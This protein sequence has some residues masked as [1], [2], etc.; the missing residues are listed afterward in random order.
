MKCGNC[1]RLLVL[2]DDF[3]PNCGCKILKTTNQ[4]TNNQVIKK[5][6]KKSNGGKILIIILS[7]IILFLLI[8]ALLLSVGTNSRVQTNN[9]HVSGN[10]GSEYNITDG[11]VENNNITDNST[12]LRKRVIMI[13]MVGSNLESTAGA[14]STDINEMLSANVDKN[15]KIYV[16]TGGANSWVNP[17]I[18]AATNNIYEI[19]NKKLKLV[20]SLESTS[21]GMEKT[22]TT[23][24]NYVTDIT[25]SNNYSLILWDH[26]GGPIGGYGYDEVHNDMMYLDELYSSLKNTKFNSNNKLEF[27]GFDACL[28]ANIEIA[29]YL[30]NF[31]KYLIASEEIEPGSGWDYETFSNISR[32]STENLGKKIIDRYAEQAKYAFNIDGFTLSLIKLDRIPKV[33]DKLNK[34]FSKMNV[35]LS[36]KYENVARTRISTLEFG[37]ST[38]DKSF[39]LIDIVNFLDIYKD[40]NLNGLKKSIE[41]VV[42]YNKTNLSGARGLSIYFPYTNNVRASNFLNQY[43]YFSNFSGYY[44]FI[45]KFHEIRNG[46]NRK[47]WDFLGNK[48]SF[49]VQDSNLSIELTEDQIKNYSKAYYIVF[50]KNEDGTYTPIYKNTNFKQVGNKLISQY[51]KKKTGIIDLDN[52]KSIIKNCGIISDEQKAKEVANDLIEIADKDGTGQITFNDTVQCLDNLDLVMNEGNIIEQG[53]HDELMRQNGFYANLYNSQFEL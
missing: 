22:L 37:K 47:S 40:N 19:K 7:I 36:K 24:I 18:D 44:K 50:E 45:F 27:I 11:V 53:N 15:T 29:S 13:Y 20:K 51:D 31:S 9:A 3:C 33:V 16:Y 28:M 30:S 6:T 35:N 14:A 32:L 46:D 52:F 39:D 10:A 43:S 26:G 25:K 34:S 1:G 8:V 5:Y 49:D 38:P 23:F 48:A 4:I 41:D 12:R 21:M 42:V 17:Q 2:E